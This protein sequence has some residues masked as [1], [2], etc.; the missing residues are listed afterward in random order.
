MLCN[1]TELKKLGFLFSKTT[2]FQLGWSFAERLRISFDL[3][4]SQQTEAFFS[5]TENFNLISPVSDG[6]KYTK[7]VLTDS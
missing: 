1:D 5:K 7:A 2:F 4:N 6:W 3:E